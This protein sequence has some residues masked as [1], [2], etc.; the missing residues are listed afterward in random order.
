MYASAVKAQPFLARETPVLLGVEA[1]CQAG[2]GRGPGTA[3][4][5]SEGGGLAAKQVTAAAGRHTRRARTLQSAV[6]QT[7]L[8]VSAPG[9]T[10]VVAPTGPGWMSVHTSSRG[11]VAARSHARR[12]I[13]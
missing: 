7:V 3:L 4:C 6:G 13:W 9:L 8:L 2:K 5:C 1:A 11:I 10:V 12:I